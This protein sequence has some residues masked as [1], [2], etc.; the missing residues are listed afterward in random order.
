MSVLK[1]LDLK[2]TQLLWES[3]KLSET[4]AKLYHSEQEQ[5]KHKKEMTK[6]RI[7]MQETLEKLDQGMLGIYDLLYKHLTLCS[8]I[9]FYSQ[10]MQHTS[11]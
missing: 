4:E 5:A 1:E 6:L 11:N 10:Q 7:K 2:R 3:N 9:I 8:R